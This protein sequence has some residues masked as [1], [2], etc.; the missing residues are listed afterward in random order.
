MK[1]LFIYALLV[2]MIPAILFADQKSADQKSAATGENGFV[3]KISLWHSVTGDK[4]KYE[5]D[6]SEQSKFDITATIEDTKWVLTGT[7]GKLVKNEIPLKLHTEWYKNKTSNEKG[8]NQIKL[9]L[10]EEKGFGVAQGVF[11]NVLMQ[12]K[13]R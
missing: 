3:L 5:I 13:A 10:N 9:K 8:D 7:I 1:N 4:V 11:I 12:G 6:I 2:I